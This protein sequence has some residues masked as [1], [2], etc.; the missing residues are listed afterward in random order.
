MVTKNGRSG[1]QLAVLG[2]HMRL[3]RNCAVGIA[4]ALMGLTSSRATPPS[5]EEQFRAPPAETRLWTFWYWVN[6]QVSKEGITHDLEAMNRF[7]I[8]TAL[9]GNVHFANL[10]V[11]AAP[12]FSENWWNL[13]LHAIREAH[14]LGIDIG[15][16]NCAGWSQSG[17]PWVKPGETMRFLNWSETH[18]AG[19]AEFHGL[20]SAP[21][22]E[23]QDVAVL[24]VPILPED[25]LK[26]TDFGPTVDAAE[27][28]DPG[29]N[30]VDDADTTI[31]RFPSG[32]ANWIVKLSLARPLTARSLELRPAAGEFKT[33]VA[34]QAQQSDGAFQTLREFEFD[35]SNRR[36]E[37][38]PVPD[39]PLVISFPATTA[40]H[41]RLMFRDIQANDVRAGLSGIQLSGASRVERV[42]EK[43]L[44]KLYSTPKP[45][46]G[47][48]M[49]P[50]QAEPERPGLAIDA[51]SVIDLA[52]K[53]RPGGNLDWD[54]PA[55]DWMVLRIGMS[56]TGIVNHPAPPNATGLEVDKMNRAAVRRHFDAFITPLLE[57]LSPDEKRTL[58]YVAADSYET[59]SENWTDDFAERF[60][61]RYGYDPK[62]WLPV[63]TGRVI[64]TVD[65]SNRFLWDMRRLVADRVASDYAGEFSRLARAHGMKFWLENYGHW[66]FP[67]EFLQYGGQSDLLSGEFWVGRELGDIE[68]RAA[69][70]AAHIYGHPIVWAEAFT[71][72]EFF[73]FYPYAMKARGD[74]AF[75]EGINHL[76][77]Q[78]SISQPGE[79]PP[80][81]NTWF[82][83]E[84]NRLNTWYE[85]GK[86]WVDY[87]R[88]CH[89]L[90]QQGRN[91]ADVAY[92]IGEDTPK[93]TGIKDP[94]LPAG[95]GFDYINAEVIETRLA[96]KDGQLV[97]PDG[98]RYA[99]LVLP[100]EET[101][102]PE[103]LAKV[104]ELVRQGANVMGRAPDR[105]PSLQDYPRADAEVK[106]L[107]TEIWSHVDERK[108]PV[109]SARDLGA[110]LAQL[111]VMPDV[112]G[113]DPHKVLWVHRRADD[114]EI[115]FVSNQTD[116]SLAVSPRFRIS[117]GVPQLW[118][119]VSGSVT[120]TARYATESGGTRVDIALPPRGSIFAVFNR[121][122]TA[123]DPGITSVT[124]DGAPDSKLVVERRGRA[125]VARC[126]DR[127]TYQV[128]LENGA[129]AMAAAREVPPAQVLAGSWQ[130][131]FP[132]QRD[133]PEALVLPALE[134][135]TAD[136]NETVR[137]F[138]GT[139]TYE[140]NFT[141]Q[142]EDITSGRRWYVDLGSVEVIA[143]VSV[144]SIGLGT[145]WTPPYRLEIT[146]AIRPGTNCLEVRVSNLWR[147]RVVGDQKYPDGFPGGP[148]P[149]QFKT[150]VTETSRLRAGEPLAPS[151]LLGPVRVMAE[152]E[153]ELEFAGR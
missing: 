130:L 48:Y 14:R 6:G 36:G 25:K 123:R 3:V 63:L 120:S 40:T 27:S 139:A 119:P 107:A 149:K 98:T 72:E 96:V 93:M 21:Q 10:P 147:N 143:D 44:A 66:G 8:G 83:T 131:L 29:A 33:Q 87:L 7:G 134:S 136:A 77:V 88:R 47:A 91:V 90:L 55:G 92:F 97:L 20:L 41:W 56:P 19:G 127:A 113:I 38:G 11:G 64:G 140:K 74:W 116:D 117:D 82:G 42:M 79:A 153:V 60:R 135:W 121:S 28:P 150:F 26:L 23:F 62:M 24:A 148:R 141:V 89:V 84:F 15:V 30:L 76:L 68:C 104:A 31:V 95:Y 69:S 105:S 2:I 43:Q 17:G 128:K 145:A 67:A 49:W 57:R 109:F 102:R 137:Y 100:D 1:R 85:S 122:S 110:A 58:K 5:L 129:T 52:S 115:Y 46:W 138:S 61:Q 101:M 54:P 37:V 70:S 65:Q 9:I 144:N 51:R 39:A 71:S 94:P 106:R 99:L 114:R 103:V 80:G 59:G 133:V 22:K 75:T 124:R 50:A 16:F 13:T 35:R 108:G 118:D 146:Q 132:P 126:P 152:Q 78:V 112:S 32:H 73:T 12:I 4:A 53:M 125:L 45:P 81:V 111:D 34:L 86:A 151:G 18:V 142:A